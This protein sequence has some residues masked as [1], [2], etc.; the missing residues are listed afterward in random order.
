[1]NIQ[2]PIAGVAFVMNAMRM[3]IRAVI[4]ADVQR[5]MVKRKLFAQRANSVTITMTND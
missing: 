3:L 2:M 5:V 4:V 1:M